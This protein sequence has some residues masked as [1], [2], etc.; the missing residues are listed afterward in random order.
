MDSLKAKGQAGQKGSLNFLDASTHIFSWL[1]VSLIPFFIMIT[2]IVLTRWS[3]GLMDDF[4]TL[5]IPGGFLQ[6][7][8]TLFHSYYQFGEFKPTLAFYAGIFYKV[9]SQHPIGFYIFKIVLSYGVLFFWGFQAYRLTRNRLAIVLVPAITLSFHYFYDVFFYLSSQEILGLLFTGL[10]VHCF[11]NTVEE[12]KRRQT[13]SA[14]LNWSLIILFLSMAFGAKE[15]FV[16][17]GMAVGCVYFFPA[18]KNRSKVLFVQGSLIILATIGHAMFLKLAIQSGYSSGYDLTNFAKMRDSVLVWFRKDLLNHLPWIAAWL[19][20]F[21]RKPLFFM[22]KGEN[23][24]QF[25]FSGIILGLLLYFGYLAILL[26]WITASY[27]A[28]PLGLFFAFLI[29][30]LICD[31][32]AGSSQKIQA[33]VLLGSMVLNI[34]V[35]QYALI[36]ETTYQQ[37]TRNLMMWM[38]A[39]AEQF[40]QSDRVVYSNAMEAGMAIPGHMKRAWNSKIQPFIYNSNVGV[41]AKNTYACYLFSPRFGAIDQKVA[42]A[43]KIK[44]VS[45]NWIVYGH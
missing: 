27:Y 11:L 10:A 7:I 38:R 31:L 29:T 14:W 15:P 17:C 41:M 12:V 13:T 44:F 19:F 40:E 2:T 35:C 20:L 43:Y 33:C 28:S 4:Q 18:I 8:T 9:F 36:R 22:R 5:E 25:Y 34:V 45:K 3:W 24:D 30:L 1:L 26:P 6:R 32:W 42:S 37:D 39:N 16:A 21:L 23:A